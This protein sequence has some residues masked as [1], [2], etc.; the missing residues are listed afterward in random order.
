MY[1][2]A[3]TLCSIPLILDS[4]EEKVPRHCFYSASRVE[5]RFDIHVLYLSS[6]RFASGFHSSNHIIILIQ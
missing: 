2:A 5:H 4:I 6:W 1:L 3:E